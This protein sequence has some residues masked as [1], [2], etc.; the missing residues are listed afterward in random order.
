M[1]KFDDWGM[2]LQKRGFKNGDA[3]DNENSGVHL[4]RHF[5]VTGGGCLLDVFVPGKY[6]RVVGCNI[7]GSFTVAEY[8]ITNPQ[9]PKNGFFGQRPT[10][11]KSRLE[12]EV[13]KWL[14]QL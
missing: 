1:T 5:R 10:A 13:T 6:F 8:P 2:I 7:P 14:K 4:N 12:G 3:G 9:T 11:E